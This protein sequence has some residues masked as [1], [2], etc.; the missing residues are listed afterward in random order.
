MSISK[1]TLSGKVSLSGMTSDAI[2]TGFNKSKSITLA[3]T[4]LTSV[5]MLSVLDLIV[6]FLR[7]DSISNYAIFVTFN[8]MMTLLG[9]F[10]TSDLIKVQ[11]RE[12]VKC[13]LAY[14]FF[15]WVCL[16]VVKLIIFV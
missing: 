14:M 13:F 11:D 8:L 16:T 6:A 1:A 10:I 2:T 12:S 7:S 4:F 15:L 9:L 3:N 5:G